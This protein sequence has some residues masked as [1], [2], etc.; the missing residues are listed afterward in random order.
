MRRKQFKH[1]SQVKANTLTGIPIIGY[2]RGRSN[3][4]GIWIYGFEIGKDP[5]FSNHRCSRT[6]IEQ[7]KEDLP[8]PEKPSKYPKLSF[9]SGDI[10]TG[11]TKTNQP[12]TGKFMQV[13]GPIVWVKTDDNTCH[14][15]KRESVRAFIS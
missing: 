3:N 12:I 11:L 7:L 15:L 8:R 2:Y 4:L 13:A 10:V 9:Q 5:I 1:N 14:K 6:S